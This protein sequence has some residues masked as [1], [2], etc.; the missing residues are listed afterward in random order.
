[1]RR[2]P[3]SIK[4]FLLA[5]AIVDDL[6]AVLVIAFFY[7]HGISVGALATAGAFFA[8]LLALNALRVHRPLPYLLLGIG[9]WAAMLA[10]GIHATV[11]GVLL[12]FTIPATRQI[13]ERT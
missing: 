7:T 10:S 6:G 2:V 9:L 8:A 5:I 4:I 13:D 11:A 3:V 1:G 12:A